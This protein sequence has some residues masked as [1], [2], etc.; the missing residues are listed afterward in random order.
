MTTAVFQP[1]PLRQNTG[2]SSRR[3]S[4]K[5]NNFAAEDVVKMTDLKVVHFFAENFWGSATEMPCPHCGTFD[6]HYW[7]RKELR[8]KCKCCDKTFS[9]TSGTVLAD[10]KMPLRKILSGLLTW[11]NAPSGVAAAKLQG[12]LRVSYGSIFTLLHKAREA[13]SRGFNTG[14]VSGTH[15]MDGLDLLGRDHAAKRGKPQVVKPAGK[16]E[17]PAHL[18]KKKEAGGDFVG[19][20]KPVKFDKK[21]KQHPD[22]RI[23]LTV[24]Q[25]GVSKGMGSIATFV[26]ISRTESAVAVTT[27]AHQHASAESHIMS[28][29]DPSY[30]SFAAHFAKHDTVNHSETFSKPGGIS[31]N[32]AESF[33]MRV[34]R[35]I[36]HIY[37]GMST[38]YLHEYCCEM[39]WRKDT[40]EMKASSRI[41]HLLS[42]LG[43]VGE[44]LFWNN[45]S[46]GKHRDHELLVDGTLPAKAHGR[47]KGWVSRRPR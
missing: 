39:A 25:R 28:D 20:E 11:M 36:K 10:H 35:G 32:Q 18:T 14:L 2:T 1:I 9:V 24:C 43:R 8:W 31:N 27:L 19:P 38:K 40:V 13:M 42:V 17:F 23:M 34:K 41:G 6:A 46:H 4:P 33:N 45:Y 37:M 21:A 16:S 22:R 47:R 3:R 44:S 30:A 15:E 26:G 7:R 12:D 29:E 5:R